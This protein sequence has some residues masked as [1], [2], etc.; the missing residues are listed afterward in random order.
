VL[1]SNDTG[2]YTVVIRISNKD[3]MNDDDATLEIAILPP[4]GEDAR[5]N[6]PFGILSHLQS[7]STQTQSPDRDWDRD[8]AGRHSHA[9]NRLVYNQQR[10]AFFRQARYGWSQFRRPAAGRWAAI[11]IGT[12]CTPKIPLPRTPAS[13]IVLGMKINLAVPRSAA[14]RR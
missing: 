11:A 14:P 12:I 13:A 2:L 1:R 3:P 10:D 8:R 4:D 9:A 7:S 5:G 6:V